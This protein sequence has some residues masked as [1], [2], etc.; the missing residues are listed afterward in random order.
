MKVRERRSSAFV[1]LKKNKARV[2]YATSK[3]VVRERK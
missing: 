1:D 3:I 2:F